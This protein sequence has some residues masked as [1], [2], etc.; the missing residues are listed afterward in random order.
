MMGVDMATRE[1][2]IAHRLSLGEM[3]RQLGVDTLE[4][5]SLEGLLAGVGRP[6]ESFC[7]ACFTGQYPVGSPAEEAK[8]A[9]DGMIA[10]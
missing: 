9:F 7:L 5:L 10:M 2:L 4:Y 6:A 3:R 1:E 8:E